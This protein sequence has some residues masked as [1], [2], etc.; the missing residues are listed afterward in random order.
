M[1]TGIGDAINL[2]WKLADVHRGRANVAI[3]D[4]YEQERIGYVWRCWW[5]RPTGP[6][7]RSSPR[8]CGAN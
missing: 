1:N 7:R 2:G 3:L 8:D 5:R 6:S 4:S